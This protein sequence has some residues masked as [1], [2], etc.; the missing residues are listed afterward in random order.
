MSH[1]YEFLLSVH[2]PMIPKTQFCEING[3]S[4]WVRGWS[5][6]EW[7]W[8]QGTNNQILSF[9]QEPIYLNQK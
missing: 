7:G 6:V 2:E 9:Y 8:E 1:R 5:G 3:N 4:G